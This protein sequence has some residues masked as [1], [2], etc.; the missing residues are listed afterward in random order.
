MSGGSQSIRHVSVAEIDR[1]RIDAAGK[2]RAVS[3]AV[4]VVGQANIGDSGFIHFRDE[5]GR[6][7]AVA[8][9]IYCIFKAA[10]REVWVLDRHQII[11]LIVTVEVYPASRIG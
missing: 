2:S 7:L 1:Y 8:S 11:Q 6:V 10:C 5:C 3:L 4:A 9:R